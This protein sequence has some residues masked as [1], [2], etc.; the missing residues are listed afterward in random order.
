LYKYLVEYCIENDMMDGMVSAGFTLV[1]DG[2]VPGDVRIAYRRN[3]ARMPRGFEQIECNRCF[4]I[5][6]NY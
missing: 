5:K 1:R 4:E 6:R 3:I 2:C